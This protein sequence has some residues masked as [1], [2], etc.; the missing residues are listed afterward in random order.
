MEDTNLRGGPHVQQELPLYPDGRH[1]RP[2]SSL[3][4]IKLRLSGLA[5][6]TFTWPSRQ[7]PH[8]L[9]WDRSL[10]E[11]EARICSQAAWLAS[12]W[13]FPATISSVMGFRQILP[14]T[15]LW[16]LGTQTQVLI[17][18]AKLFPLRH[19][20]SLRSLCFLITKRWPCFIIKIPFYC[21][22]LK[23]RK[24]KVCHA[25]AWTNLQCWVK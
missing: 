12:F 20:L 14:H 8:L 9:F 17:L 7:L 13:D 5:A 11:L 22:L 4:S 18:M 10:I 25:T 19:L 23:H 15:A 21:I 6:I 2:S 16:V 1:I 3:R 24:H